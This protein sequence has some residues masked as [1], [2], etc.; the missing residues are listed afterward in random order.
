M[1]D[2]WLE[3]GMDREREDNRCSVANI[4]SLR[5]SSRGS[6]TSEG[7]AWSAWMY[8]SIYSSAYPIYMDV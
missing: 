2:R 8:E 1:G 4:S 3:L 6:T 7:G 5:V